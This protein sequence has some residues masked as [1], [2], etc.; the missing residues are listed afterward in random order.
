MF[1]VNQLFTKNYLLLYITLSLVHFKSLEV[2]H[3]QSLSVS[4]NYQNNEVTSIKKLLEVPQ[5][6]SLCYEI[7]Q[8]DL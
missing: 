5:S 1:N 2:I 6:I 4:K 7:T 3:S 8:S